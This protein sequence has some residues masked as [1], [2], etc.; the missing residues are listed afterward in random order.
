MNFLNDNN[1]KKMFFII[2]GLLIIDIMM[3]IKN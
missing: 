3:S 1:S 2:T